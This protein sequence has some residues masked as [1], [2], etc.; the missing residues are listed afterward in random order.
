MHYIYL[1][2]YAKKSSFSPVLVKSKLWYL[3]Q[4]LIHSSSLRVTP[5]FSWRDNTLIGHFFQGRIYRRPA[6]VSKANPQT[7]ANYA[8]RWHCNTPQDKASIHCTCEYTIM[9]RGTHDARCFLGFISITSVTLSTTNHLTK[10]I[11]VCSHQLA[12]PVSICAI[13]GCFSRTTNNQL[14]PEGNNITRKV[15][16][17]KAYSAKRWA[18]KKLNGVRLA[19]GLIIHTHLHTTTADQWILLGFSP[20]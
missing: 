11:F 5:G 2:I 6:A 20:R 4:D 17:C 8:N 9:F 14:Q 3:W 1:C 12:Q 7:N 19:G 10:L 15:H 13:V 16:V 18:N